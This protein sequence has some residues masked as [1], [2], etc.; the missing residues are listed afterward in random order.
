MEEDEQSTSSL[1]ASPF[2]F[3]YHQ[4]SLSSHSM[5]NY[6]PY[7]QQQQVPMF[8]PGSSSNSLM[9]SPTNVVP[10]NE[11]QPDDYFIGNH[12]GSSGQTET[13]SSPGAASLL[14]HGPMNPT[15]AGSMS[16]EDLL[17]LYYNGSTPVTPE[18]NPDMFMHQR[19]T[20]TFSP[21]IRQEYGKLDMLHLDPKSPSADSEGSSSFD[22]NSM[23]TGSFTK[24]TG[25]PA[26]KE[27]VKSESNLCFF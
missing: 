18:G 23:H 27:M 21:D 22:V 11:T 7:H 5:P 3:A 9:A 6:G 25:N 10:E 15:N 16:F 20:M 1:A 4:K 17:T 8:H 26:D 14:N 12:L 19:S 24:G 2:T 13:T